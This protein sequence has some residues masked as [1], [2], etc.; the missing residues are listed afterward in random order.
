MATD[1]DRARW[2]GM[3]AKALTEKDTAAQLGTE[4]ARRKF[5]RIYFVG[6]GAPNRE[7]GAIKYWMD[8][9]VR[10][11]EVRL[12][13]PAEFTAQAP[14]LADDPETLVI[15]GSHSGK[16]P[17]TVSAAKWARSLRCTT[18]GV[19]QRFE[20]DLAQNVAFPLTYGASPDDGYQHGYFAMY[21]VLAALTSALM[22]DLEGATYHD[23]MMA[24][25]AV[26]PDVLADAMFANE[27]RATEEARLYHGTKHLFVVGSG[28]MW[29]TA[30][31]FGVCI[32]MEMQ[33]LQT[34]PCEAAEF[35]HG[36]FEIVDNTTQMILLLGEDPSR[37]LAER[38]VRFAKR[39]TERLMIYDSYSFAM[40]GVS[41]AIRPMFAPFVLQAALDRYAEH[42]AVWHAHPL[43]TRRYMWKTEY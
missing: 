26:L 9:D 24:A 37:P 12:Y 5:R 27:A 33:H 39:Y 43:N 31:V 32:L 17:E 3:F 21:M 42:L 38:V 18:V 29:T 2:V 16:T 41:P 6:C 15:L 14:A 4:L 34:Y 11:T 7:M 19:T 23:E 8:K 28:P 36:P 40:N 30:Y 20:S 10:S 13:F 35:F 22:R 1:I 25:L